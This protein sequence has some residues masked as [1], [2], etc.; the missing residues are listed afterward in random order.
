[1]PQSLPGHGIQAVEMPPHQHLSILLQVKIETLLVAKSPQD[2]GGVIAETA[3]MEYPNQSF[4]QIALPAVGVEQVT[5]GVRPEGNGH[6]IDG[7]VPSPE[8]IL[9][10][11]RF[12]LR[13]STRPGIDLRPCRDQVEAE[14]LLIELGC[15]K[16]RVGSHPPI[17][18]SGYLASQGDGV[19]LNH[20]IEV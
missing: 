2:A 16:A 7:E 18:D 6:G 5:E 14:I 19:A 15:P 11:A 1:M 3:P 9:D 12:H 8:V 4:P 17:L 10:C 13:Q 20:Q